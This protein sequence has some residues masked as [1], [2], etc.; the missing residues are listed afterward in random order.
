[1]RD[2]SGSSRRSGCALPRSRAP[3]ERDAAPQRSGRPAGAANPKDFE[4]AWKLAQARYWLGTNGLPEAGAQGSARGRHRR[5][6]R[7]DRASTRER[8]T[9]TSGLPPTWAR[10]PS[11]SA[12]GRGSSIAARFGR[13]RNGAE[14]RSRVP[15][16]LSRS[17]AWPL[18]LTRCP[19]CSAAATRNR[20]QHLRKSL[21]YNPN[22]VISH[23]FLAETL[24]EL[25]RK[26]E[27]R[28][29]LTPRSTRRSIPNGRPRIAAS[30]SRRNGC[31]RSCESKAP[32]RRRASAILQSVASENLSLCGA[33][34]FA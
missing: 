5:R 9:A 12:C 33:F 21:T 14:A 20:K 8:P 19:G 6:T 31:S 15:R 32:Q 3:R 17:R 1:M 30:R 28:K 11:R 24:V 16:R 2:R 4:S 29:E 18:V 13:A 26:D 7:G 10:S 25:G 27:A 23:L 22:S 34:Y